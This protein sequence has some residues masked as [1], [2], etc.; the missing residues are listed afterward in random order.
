MEQMRK[1]V[2]GVV[3]RTTG[4]RGGRVIMVGMSFLRAVKDAKGISTGD[5]EC[6]L[7]GE[8]FKP[9]PANRTEMQLVFA[10]HMR[11]AHPIDS[12]QARD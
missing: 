8:R 12:P 10:E 11:N 4:I 3:R 5:F 7:C 2:R 9:N 6:S 1:S